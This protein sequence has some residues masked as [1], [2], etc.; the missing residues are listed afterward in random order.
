MTER[1]LRYF[2][3]KQDI[4][5]VLVSMGLDDICTVESGED[6]D[7]KIYLSDTLDDDSY[8]DLCESL[9]DGLYAEQD[10]SIA[11]AL[12]EFLTE[13]ALVLSTAESCTG[14]MVASKLIDVPGASKFFHEGVVTYSNQSKMERLSVDSKTLA[15]YGA[16]S[17]EVA[18]EMAFG[19]LNQYVD[20][21]VS[22]TGIAGPTGE[23]MA[24]VFKPVGLV[25]VGIAFRSYDP[26][27]MKFNFRGSRNDIRAAAT[28]AA[29]FYTYKYLRDNL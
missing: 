19:L 12:A 6:L 22:T 16:V 7:N 18:K 28:N 2:G 1:I 24:N 20:V 5:K 29:L 17:A 3:R 26:I 4:D 9:E 8:F 13:N 11:E 15:K 21:A 14:G 27:A 10:K 23:T 25:Y